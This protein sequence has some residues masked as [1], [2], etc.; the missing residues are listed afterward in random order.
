MKKDLTNVTGYIYKITSPNGEVYIGQTI[1]LKER[2]RSYNKGDY[3]KQTKL[4]NNCHFYAWNPIDTFE[5]ID[6]CL[7][8]ED[9]INLN[10]K[11]IYWISYYDSYK[12]GL[13]CT[14]GGKGQTGKIW[15]KEERQRQREITLENGTAFKIGNQSTLG[16]KA[17][18]ETK[19]R[20]SESNKS[21][22]KKGR[23]PWNKGKE[24]TQEV[25][26]KIIIST[27]GEKNHFY[28]KTHSDE[29]KE[30][31]KESKLG[32]KH[33]EETKEKMRKSSKRMYH[34]HFYGKSVLQY[35]MENNFIRRY[36]SIKDASQQ[37][38]CS[39]ARIVDVC[40][41]RRNH[42]KKF[43]FKYEENPTF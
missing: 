12:N 28:G 19:K 24:T 39:K 32:S 31:I 41:G 9:K 21:T 7:C 42:T 34:P 16:T 18:K 23:V 25:K 36:E 1:N 20:I 17:S 13:N 37:T 35:D 6:E 29:T 26:E 8:G 3:K 27:S 14:I 22:Y 15:T 2:R 4:F 38:G 30:K 33:S 5:I 40:K 10:E 43:V 11:E